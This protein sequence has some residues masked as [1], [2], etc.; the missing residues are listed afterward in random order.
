MGHHQQEELCSKLQKR[1]DQLKSECHQKRTMHGWRRIEEVLAVLAT[2]RCRSSAG[3]A[4]ANKG[5]NE[6]GRQAEA[7]FAQVKVCR[8][9]ML[10]RKSKSAT[11]SAAAR[12]Q[13]LSPESSN[14]DSILY[15]P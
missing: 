6:R 10:M 12:Q 8:M 11:Q 3:R 4:E 1:I 15:V 13:L 9:L 7:D 2:S 5:R 14:A